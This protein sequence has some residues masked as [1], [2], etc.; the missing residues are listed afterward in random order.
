MLL[1][2]TSKIAFGINRKGISIAALIIAILLSSCNSKVID[3]KVNIVQYQ[4]PVLKGLEINPVLQL[5][6]CPI[7][8]TETEITGFTFSLDGTSDLGDIKAIK[9]LH[10]S[11]KKYFENSEIF[12]QEQPPQQQPEQSPDQP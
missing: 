3:L 9:I 8:G 10:A 6:L 1:A 4:V 11:K 5:E 12:G 2:K 7:T